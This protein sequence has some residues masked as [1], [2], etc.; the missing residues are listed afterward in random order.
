MREYLRVIATRHDGSTYQNPLML[1]EIHLL[2]TLARL[3]NRLEVSIEKCTIG[4]FKSIFG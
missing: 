2:K 4:E 3:N 1:S